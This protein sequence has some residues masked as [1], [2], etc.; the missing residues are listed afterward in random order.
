MPRYLDLRWWPAGTTPT[1]EERGCGPWAGWFAPEGAFEGAPL[2]LARNPAVLGG[3]TPAGSVSPWRSA[4]QSTEGK[5]LV[6][7]WEPLLCGQA[8][9]AV[10][11]LGHTHG[12]PSLK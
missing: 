11:S 12:P 5:R 9:A 8:M 1:E 10:P 4:H 7:A 2:T 3:G 6:R